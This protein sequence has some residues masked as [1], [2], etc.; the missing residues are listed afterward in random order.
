MPCVSCS[1]NHL[2]GPLPQF[3]NY[4]NVPASSRF[5]IRVAVRLFPALIR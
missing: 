5:G 4:S 2:N 1:Y 3:M